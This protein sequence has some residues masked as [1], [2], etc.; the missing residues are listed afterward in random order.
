MTGQGLFFLKKMTGRKLSSGKEK[1]YLT[2]NDINVLCHEGFGVFDSTINK[3]KRFSAADAYLKPAKN[4]NN[5]TILSESHVNKII[6]KNKVAV[7]V[8]FFDKQ[9]NKVLAYASKAVSYT[10][11]TLPTKA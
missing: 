1:N 9:K 11:L 4:R 8:E 10:H 3:G 2:T 5:L 7:G 6:F